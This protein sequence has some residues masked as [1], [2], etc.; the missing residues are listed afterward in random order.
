MRTPSFKP[1]FSST[2]RF[3][4]FLVIGLF[5]LL[6]FFSIISTTAA[7]FPQKTTSFQPNPQ[8]R[9]LF[10]QSYQQL[11]QGQLLDIN[12]LMAELG[13]YP[14][15]PYLQYQYFRNQIAYQQ[16][17]K[18]QLLAFLRR[19]QNTP[20][21]AR[22]QNEWLQLLG[23]QQAWDTYY[24]LTG[25]V[26]QS[27]TQLEC[28]RRLAEA[29]QQGKSLQWLEETADFWRQNQPFPSNCSKLVE[30]LVQLGLL[31]ED[32][33]WQA[34]VDLLKRG[35][36]Q[37]AWQ[38][39]Q[40]L[41]GAQRDLIDFW[42][43]GYLN[44]LGQLN[45][46]ASNPPAV[47]KQFPE[48]QQPL[49]VDLLKQGIASQPE[50]TQQ[51]LHQLVA[52]EQLNTAAAYQVQ[53]ALAIH[54]AGRNFPQT[55]SWFAT[56]PYEQRSAEARVWYARSHLRAENWSQLLNATDQLKPAD[57][58]SNEWQYWRAQALQQTGQTQAASQLLQKLSQER[59][60]YGFMAARELG[61]PPQMNATP[62]SLSP[63]DLEELASQPGII[64]AGELF[65]LGFHEDARR[66]WHA[67][68]AGASAETWQQ[69]AW[70]A[71]HWGWYDR[72]INAIHRAGQHNALELRFP[73][74]HLP[75]L[76]P[77]AEA[78]EVDLAL[79]LAL[80]RKES[81]FDA[82]ARSRVGALGL[83]QVMPATGQE[84]M[85]A[86][87]LPNAN[88]QSLLKPQYNL[89]VGVHYLAGLLES[90]QQDPILAAAAYNAGPRHANR[91]LEAH[92][93]EVNP[94][95]VEQ[96]TFAETRDYVKSLVAFREVYAWL[97]QEQDQRNTR[98]AYVP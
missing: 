25:P 10:S 79:V 49:L 61:T 56:L 69:A 20:W 7:F 94:L 53:E 6:L 18:D 3:K 47:L 54:A 23:R 91:W 1:V 17:D 21:Q 92:G 66:E 24:Q 36:A 16:V 80:I 15:A 14:L 55:F 90:F 46:V 26:K 5:T 64:R 43:R 71:Q 35:Q 40:E 39:G 34:A 82:Q 89:S 67:S 88:T 73:L 68:L 45:R 84:V 4:A 78:A 12:A 60:Y 81:L 38:L 29:D 85:Q 77:L 65:L 83:M 9:Q 30:P 37:A 31:T 98:V 41:S 27:S 48:L 97:L 13:D 93:G 42:R 33:F 95:W 19:H 50:Q 11:Q 75:T 57:A 62:A 58:R 63:P 22:L 74:A 44:P 51:R 28:Y 32:D 76:Q 59:N 70:L 8:A 52:A 86:L 2:R 87:Q 72:S 96:I